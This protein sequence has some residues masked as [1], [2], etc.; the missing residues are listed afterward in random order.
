MMQDIQPE[1]IEKYQLLLEKDPKSQVFAPLSEAY[2]K[3]DMLE[4]ALKIATRGVKYNPTF[5][6]GRIALARLLLDQ[7]NFA[8][9]IQELEKAIELSPDNI[10]AHSLLGECYLS[11]KR[12]KDA[13][14]AYKM[15]LFLSP[16]NEKAL[17]AV[18]KLESLTADEFDEEL[19]EM[20]RLPDLQNESAKRRGVDTSFEETVRIQ[21]LDQGQMGSEKFQSLDRYLSMVDAYI[22]RNDVDRAWSLVQ[23]AEKFHSGSKE[24]EKR[25]KLLQS[26]SEDVIQEAELPAKAAKAK[27]PTR[28]ELL[29]DSRIDLLKD[30]LAK[31][32]AY[33]QFTDRT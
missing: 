26:R 18:K 25:V 32:R 16:I 9:A 8:G 27:L 24:L 22:V 11:Q 19:F 7:E 2:R 30:L 21:P 13:L 12:P 33:S 28:S 15:V 31:V 6:G 17:R 10:L 29:R 5:A 20:K 3:M 14:K 23:E 1:L 4:E